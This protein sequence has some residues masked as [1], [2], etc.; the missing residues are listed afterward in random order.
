MAHHRYDVLEE[1]L[2]DLDDERN[3]IYLH[4]DKKSK[5]FTGKVKRQLQQV[6]KRSGLYFVPRR[7]VYWGHYSQ[8]KCVVEL[9]Q[10]AT[11]VQNYD[12]YHLLV[13]VE[14]PLKSQDEIHRFF[15]AN[16]GCEFVGFDHDNKE[17]LGRVKY[18]HLTEK[19]ARVYKRIPQSLYM[20]CPEI[21]AFQ[22]KHGV[23][24]THGKGE[25]YYKKGYANWSI[26]DALAR[27]IIKQWKAIKK[28]YRLTYCADEVFIH[29]II[30]HSD[31]YSKVY[32]LEDEYH[33]CMRLTTW[34]SPINQLT[35]KDVQLLKNSEM[36]FARKIDG[37]DAIELIDEIK[38]NRE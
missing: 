16:K 14:F 17:K 15:E 13:G 37:E 7:T 32:D 3:D 8:I 26:T 4:I 5:D 36:L 29:T 27:E 11:K 38:K 30:Y 35:L 20:K 31:F 18:Y 9:L 22:E 19:Y 25:S 12:Y 23:D 24:R 21:I 28:E 10:Q 1:L 2:K 34:N 6:V 33:S